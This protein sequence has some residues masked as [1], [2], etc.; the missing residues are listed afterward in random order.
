[1]SIDILLKKKKKDIFAWEMWEYLT[2]V[3]WKP[4]DPKAPSLHFLLYPCA[5]WASHHE[6]R[7]TLRTRGRR[8]TEH[9]EGSERVADGLYYSAAY[10]QITLRGDYLGRRMQILQLGL[11]VQTNLPPLVRVNDVMVQEQY[12]CRT[13]PDGESP[14][15]WSTGM[16]S[17][18]QGK[19]CCHPWP[20]FFLKAVE[21]HYRRER[22]SA[23]SCHVSDGG[24][25][26]LDPY[27]RY[28]AWIPS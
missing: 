11:P 25:R 20:Y 16:W 18:S 19:V 23:V 2:S 22:E 15:C 4:L 5:T 28:A 9:S 6:S 1:M 27:K 7:Q 14:N 12:C 17:K 21:S 3:Q 26:P 24:S 8:F 13:V 10:A